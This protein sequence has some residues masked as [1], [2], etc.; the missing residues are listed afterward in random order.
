MVG[1]RKG[2]VVHFED[3]EA[4]EFGKEAPGT[5]IRKIIDDEN[6][7]APNYIFRIIEVAPGGHTPRHTHPYEHQNYV[8]SGRGRVLI[9]GTWYDL[10]PGRV[11]FVPPDIEHIYENTGDETLRFICVIP[12]ERLWGREG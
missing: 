1:K 11:A 6:D 8:I 3:V 10:E 12:V 7:G 2:K 9:G 4:K 5:R